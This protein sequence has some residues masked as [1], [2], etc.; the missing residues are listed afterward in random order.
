MSDEARPILLVVEDEPDIN[1]V[2]A[3]YGEKNGY[4]VHCADNGLDAVETAKRVRP[5][6]ILLDIALPGLDGRDVMIRLKQEGLTEH[7]V[8]IFLTARDEQSDRLLG[9]E[10]GADDYETKPVHFQMLFRKVE[11][12]LTK[13]RGS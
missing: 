5:D 2:L 3:T 13:K 7:A 8:V 9:L 1:K 10:L 4:E 12:L 6:V 11:R